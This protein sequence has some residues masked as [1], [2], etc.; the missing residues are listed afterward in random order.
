MPRTQSKTSIIRIPNRVNITMQWKPNVTVAAVV[1]QND[2]FLLVE[3][4]DKG[5]IVFNQPAGHLEK[6]ET[7]IDA[8]KRE[9]MEE[10]ACEFEPE[11]I[12]GVYLHPDTGSDITYLRVCFAGTVNNQHKDRKLDDGIIRAVWMTTDELNTSV[13]KMRSAMVRRCI[14]DYLS[15]K[16]YPLGLLNHYLD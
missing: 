10:T 15:G 16:R 7:L 3:E 5:R 11:F 1:Q 13:D 12:V 6:N 2:H 8:V 4:N 9:V 14:E